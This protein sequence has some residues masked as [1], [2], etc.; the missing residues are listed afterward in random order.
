M[1]LALTLGYLS[2]E[3]GSVATDAA[4]ALDLALA[5]EGAGYAQVWVGEAYGT[6]AP[7]V[8]GWLA[9]QTSTI[10]LG[11]A[12]MQVPARSAASTAM[13]AASLD[14]LSGGRFH[15]GLGVSGPQVSSGWHG[16]GFDKPLARTRAYVETVRTALA[17]RPVPPQG[18]GDDLPALRLALPA[19][20]ADLPVYLAALGP[21]NTELAG[22]IA[23]GWL[24]VFF[25]PEHAGEAMDHLAAGRARAADP[26]RD[27]AVVPTV[28]L[29]VTGAAGATGGDADGEE[30][31][32]MARLAAHTA[33]YVGGMGSASLNVYRDAATRMGHGEA[34]SRITEHYLSGRRREAAAAV[35]LE[36]VRSTGLVGDPD[37]IAGRLA[38][39]A[40]AGVTTVSVTPMAATPAGRQRALTVAAEALSAC[41]AGS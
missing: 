25:S 29:V 16:V 8:L 10:G 7:S 38:A 33:L 20:R 17:R 37:D 24:P 28:P 14:A 27:V 19:P 32:A 40:A 2:G 13:T 18:P 21:R 26:S 6:D 12:V 31:A 9:A 34:A 22:E 23:D 3:S 1:R 30:A 5:A 15:L 4:H 35:P 41:G 36:L 39:H 11:S